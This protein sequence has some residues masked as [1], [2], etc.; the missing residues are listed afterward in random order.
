MN[1]PILVVVVATV[2]RYYPLATIA[3]TTMLVR[4]GPELTLADI[5]AQPAQPRK[6]PSHQHHVSHHHTSQTPAAQGHND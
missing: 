2:A 4:Y 3:T 6:Q 5:I 1:I